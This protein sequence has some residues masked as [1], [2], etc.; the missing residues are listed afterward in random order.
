M[1]KE[2][3]TKEQLEFERLALRANKRYDPGVVQF[4]RAMRRAESVLRAAESDT[5]ATGLI[6]ELNAKWPFHAQDVVLSGRIYLNEND[7]NLEIDEYIPEA[8]GSKK[9]DRWG[10]FY[11]VEE[12]TLVS[13]GVGEVSGDSDPAQSSICFVFG[14]SEDDDEPTF[15]ARQDDIYKSEYPYPTYEACKAHLEHEYPA[16]FGEIN[17]LIRPATQNF[18]RL[19]SVLQQI[20]NDHPEICEDPILGNWAAV[21]INRRIKFDK[22][23]PYGFVIQGEISLPDED[24]DDVIYEVSEPFAF[25]ARITSIAFAQVYKGD[26]DDQ[27]TNVLCY[28]LTLPSGISTAGEYADSQAIVRAESVLS[29]EPRRPIVSLRDQLESG[30]LE[31]IKSAIAQTG[32]LRLAEIPLESIDNFGDQDAEN[33][34]EPT[35]QESWREL[36]T[37]FGAMIDKLKQLRR[38]TFRNRESAL[39]AAATLA[40]EMNGSLNAID[41]LYQTAFYARGTGVGIP[42]VRTTRQVEDGEER[43]I[44]QVDSNTKTPSRAMDVF[45]TFLALEPTVEELDEESFKPLI[46]GMFGYQQEAPPFRM[47]EFE[48][49]PL[50]AAT[51]SQVSM[52][53]MDDTATVTVAGLDRIRR[54]DRVMKDL[55]KRDGIRSEK[56]AIARLYEAIKSEHPHEVV[57]LRDLSLLRRFDSILRTT[58]RPNEVASALNAILGDG[59]QL[60]IAGQAIDREGNIHETDTTVVT[61][62]NVALEI[63]NFGNAVPA[64]IVKPYGPTLASQLDAAVPILYFPLRSI[65][66]LRY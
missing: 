3:G 65:S 48:S 9:Y 18:N 14:F 20:V 24:G 39:E 27:A 6:E 16:L 61:C 26:S 2:T 1:T 23:S 66:S 43:L 51:V 35:I 25:D 33:D 52:V 21:Y 34:A 5:E 64:L 54:R 38:Q 37:R 36:E 11:E 12:V 55:A 19:N 42:S 30:R 7:E 10:T 62:L 31:A 44:I 60:L 45:G 32:M 49:V 41:V 29:I 63:P 8:W 46:L 13:M 15:S 47:L 28:M 53:R 57:A 40:T 22:D 56:I 59:R 50:V 58:S 17:R 4:L